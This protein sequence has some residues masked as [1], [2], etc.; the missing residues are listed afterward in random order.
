MSL[1]LRCFA[2]IPLMLL[3]APAAATNPPFTLAYRYHLPTQPAF[4]PGAIPVIANDFS[5]DGRVDIIVA[6]RDVPLM[7]FVAQK[8]DRGGFV[9]KTLPVFHN[10]V[11][12]MLDRQLIGAGSPASAGNAN[13]VVFPNSNHSL[14]RAQR[15]GGQASF[16]AQYD[17]IELPPNN[18]AVGLI[19][20]LVAG[21]FNGD[22]YTDVAIIDIPDDVNRDHRTSGV[23]A[24]GRF[25][26]PTVDRGLATVA[27]PYFIAAADFVDDAAHRTDLLVA[28]ISDRIGLSAYEPSPQRYALRQTLT[29]PG[30]LSMSALTAG[31]LD[32]DGKPDAIAT[33]RLAAGGYRSSLIENRGVQGLALGPTLSLGN[34]RSHCIADFNADGTPDLLVD[35]RRLEL[36]RGHFAYDTTPAMTTEPT[37]GLA[38]ADFNGDGFRD[39]AVVMNGP[40][41]TM[42]LRIY[43]YDESWDRIFGNGFQR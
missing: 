41:N 42:E 34:A 11:S 30:A 26:Q 38:C 4:E 19:A 15:V 33:Y 24:W 3:A 27:D 1:S 28:S 25:G 17:R 12:P 35:G 18:G 8:P 7:L 14:R 16:A 21:D 6:L 32:G 13:D 20:N 37:Y 10:Y 39:F 36:G 31:D 5:F 43:Q 22:H 29:V 40:D 23:I 2:P 9:P